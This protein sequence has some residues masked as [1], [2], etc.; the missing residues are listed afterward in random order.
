MPR[1]LPVLRLSAFLL[2]ALT[3]ASMAAAK[4]RLIG[5]KLPVKLKE[6]WA[7]GFDCS[8]RNV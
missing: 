6:I 8:S 7:I 4:G 3:A 5:Q 2:F 1:L